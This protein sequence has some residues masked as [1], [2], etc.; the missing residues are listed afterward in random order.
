MEEEPKEEILELPQEVKFE[1]LHATCLD[2]N[3]TFMPSG[4]DTLSGMKSEVC[5]KCWL[6]RTISTKE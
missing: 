2:G 1:P 5:T 6:G 3:H 4:E